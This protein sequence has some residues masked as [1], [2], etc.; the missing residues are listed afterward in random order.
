MPKNTR[1]DEFYKKIHNPKNNIPEYISI[2]IRP[3]KK[4]LDFK[5]KKEEANILKI[6]AHEEGGKGWFLSSAHVPIVNFGLTPENKNKDFLPILNN[7]VQIKNKSTRTF[8]EEIIRKYL[9]V[10]PERKKHFF[11]TERFKKKKSS[12]MGAQKKGF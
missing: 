6:I 3:G 12:Q 5:I 2:G 8:M 9:E 1:L 4:I 11:I 7:P 10:L